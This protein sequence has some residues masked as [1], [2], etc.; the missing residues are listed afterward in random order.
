MNT[1]TQTTVSRT[2][3]RLSLIFIFSLFAAPVVVAWLV[4]FV[5]PDWKPTGT[6][7]HGQL[8]S[9]VRLLPV[10]ELGTVA[11]EFVDN[12]YLRGKW[13][14]VSVLQGECEESCVQLLYKVR[15]VRLTQGKNIDRV[16][17]LLLWSTNGV[18]P[19]KQRDLQA[20]FPGLVI[21]DLNVEEH[22]E[23]LKTLQ[24]DDIDP[25]QASRTYLVDP[26]GNVM[27]SYE[28]DTEPR[29]IVKDLERLLKYSSLR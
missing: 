4:F 12:S 9:P 15:Q 19:D 22:G 7:H 29:G 6:S 8:V 2:R 18:S 3:S 25:F 14:F 26:L 17:R 16:Q 20:H 23:L 24:L 27:M 21:A 11:G 1:E 10:F 13:T 28:Q 5:F